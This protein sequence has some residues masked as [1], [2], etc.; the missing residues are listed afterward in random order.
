MKGVVVVDTNLLVLLVVG[1]AS[2][3]YIAM[4]KRLAEYTA[5]DFDMLGLILAEFS[6]I[7]LLPHVLA[8]ASNF[9]RMIDFPARAKV[10]A[11]LST[12]ISS[13]VELPIPSINGVRRSEFYDL[14]LTDAVI[15][16]LCA[17]ILNGIGPTLVTADA[18]L[19]NAANSLGYSVIDYRQDF[20]QG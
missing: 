6:E 13:C 10:Q 3:N 1:S 2:R 8:E 16:H 12:L 9:A 19:A 5:D 14:G 20:L 4:H 18:K 15:L 11:A 7:V 17:M